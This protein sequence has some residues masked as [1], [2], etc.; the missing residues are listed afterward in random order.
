MQKNLDPRVSVDKTKVQ[1]ACS[2]ETDL[3]EDN[4]E[5]MGEV[6]SFSY[7]GS[8]QKSSGDAEFDIRLGA[9]R[10]AG[11]FKKLLKMRTRNVY[12]NTKLRLFNAIAISTAAYAA[13]TWISTIKSYRQL[14]TFQNRCLRKIL[15]VHWQD[16]ITNK[17]ILRRIKSTGLSTTIMSRRVQIIG[18]I[19]R[20][21]HDLPATVALDWRPEGGKRPRDIP[22]KSLRSTI[23]QDLRDCGTK[24]YQSPKLATDRKKWTDVVVC[25]RQSG[26]TTF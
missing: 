8:I 5:M 13:D 21:S 14:E 9:E 20:M 25:W 23:M 2:T 12:V 15:G 6:E 10:G 19:L 16:R 1:K 24:W 22:K 26:G 18:H 3:L 7:L 4:D 17:E 11:V